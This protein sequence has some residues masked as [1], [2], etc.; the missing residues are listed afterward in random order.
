M[1]ENLAKNF[2]W[3]SS[4]LLNAFILFVKKKN[5][6]LEMCVNYYGFNKVIIKNWYS[7][8]LILSL[9]D[10]LSQAKIY[11]KIYLHGAYSFVGIKACNEWKTT[12][13]TRYRHFEYNV[14]LF[15]FINAPAIFQHLMNG[16]LQKF[17]NNF[18]VIHLDDVSWSF[19]NI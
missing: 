19:H 17:L 11:S 14:M 9:F 10:Q 12:F 8:L 7:F 5:E 16:I 18:V 4:S 13:Q 6:C 2:I 3:R 1:D 15:K